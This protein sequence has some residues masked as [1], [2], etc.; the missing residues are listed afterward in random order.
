MSTELQE[1][2]EIINVLRQERDQGPLQ[3]YIPFN[4]EEK[5]AVLEGGEASIASEQ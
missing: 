4:V 3:N 2:Y 5:I 1:N